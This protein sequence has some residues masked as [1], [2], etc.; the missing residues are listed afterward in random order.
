MSDYIDI[1]KAREAL[2]EGESLVV[3]T[4]DSKRGYII[5]IGD[6]DASNTWA[7]TAAE[8]WE[9]RNLICAELST[10]H[11]TDLD[12]VVGKLFHMIEKSSDSTVTATC[13]ELLNYIEAMHPPLKVT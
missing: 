7:V 8:L 6:N 13:R 5:H 11:R 3:L 1:D 4:G 10:I 9:L 12:D 2:A